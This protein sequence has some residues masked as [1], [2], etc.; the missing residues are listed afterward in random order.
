MIPEHLFIHLSNI[1]SFPEA[2]LQILKTN[3]WLPKGKHGGEGI[4]QELGMNIHTLLCIR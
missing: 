3:I 2:D 1:T 4:N